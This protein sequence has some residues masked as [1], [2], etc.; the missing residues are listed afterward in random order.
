MEQGYD[1]PV[2]TFPTFPQWNFKFDFPEP[3]YKTKPEPY[4]AMEITETRTYAT[5]LRWIQ[6]PYEMESSISYIIIVANSFYG[7]ENYTGG[8]LNN[9]WINTYIPSK[10]SYK[11]IRGDRRGIEITEVT[12]KYSTSWFVLRVGA[13][14][15]GEIE[16]QATDGNSKITRRIRVGLPLDCSGNP[17]TIVQNNSISLEVVGGVKPLEWTLTNVGTSSGF[18]ITPNDRKATLSA[19][20]DASGSVTVRVTDK[21]G[22]YCEILVLCDEGVEVV[23]GESCTGN[24]ATAV[25]CIL[26]YIT[27][28]EDTFG[29]TIDGWS[30]RFYSSLSYRNAARDVYTADVLAAGCGGGC[31]GT[32]V[33][34][35]DCGEEANS[36]EWVFKRNW[37]WCSGVGKGQIVFFVSLGGF[38]AWDATTWERY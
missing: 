2:F 19:S 1:F 36:Q 16:L 9:D 8:R 18:T 10:L 27:S 23:D 26:D 38:T 4:P 25:Q 7:T 32:G 29:S 28:I 3:I 15:E 33:Y 30:V 14:V 22:V 11:W 31:C 12:H 20:S 13:D 35:N 6:C 5:G 21:K 37:E 24:A 34:Y 17:T